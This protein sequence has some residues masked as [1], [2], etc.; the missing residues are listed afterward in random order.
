[1]IHDGHRNPYRAATT[2]VSDAGANTV[3]P[4]TFA[5]REQE[6]LALYVSGHTVA[7][8]VQIMHLSC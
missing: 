6:V 4:S 3:S 7:E 1:M 2:R 8:V 5:L